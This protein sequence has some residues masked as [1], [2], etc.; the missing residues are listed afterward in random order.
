MLKNILPKEDSTDGQLVTLYQQAL[1]LVYPSLYEGFGLPVLEAMANGCPVIASN[2]TPIPEVTGSAVLYIDPVDPDN[3][4]QVFKTCIET[5]T[6]QKELSE[7]GFVQNKMFSKK[8]FIS[9]MTDVFEQAI[10]SYQ[11]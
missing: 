7:K 11:R 10:R 2:S 8:K 1:C 3:M 5:P 9:G 4:L 6:L